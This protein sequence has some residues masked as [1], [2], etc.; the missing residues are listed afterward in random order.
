MANVMK[1][2]R[3]YAPLLL[4]AFLA[5]LAISPLRAEGFALI[6]GIKGYPHF[7]AEQRLQYADED[8]RGFYEFIQTKAGGSFR[9][10]NIRLLINEEA[11]R[12][13]IF[14]AVSWLRRT[15]SESDTLY[16]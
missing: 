13:N 16:V 10:E 15:T 7:E 1:K 9:R 5:S 6:I 4:S 12:D 3:S 2:N 14:D 8:A 11:S